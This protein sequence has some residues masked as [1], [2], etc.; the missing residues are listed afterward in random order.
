VDKIT[1]AMPTDRWLTKR[2]S[3]STL[4]A[5]PFLALNARDFG[6]LATIRPSGSPPRCRFWTQFLKLGSANHVCDL[7]VGRPV[8]TGSAVINQQSARPIFAQ[9][10]ITILPLRRR[11]LGLGRIRKNEII[12]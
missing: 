12:P 2:H 1:I 9:R 8:G 5:T 4:P 11:A 3:I 10:S 6:G 7:C